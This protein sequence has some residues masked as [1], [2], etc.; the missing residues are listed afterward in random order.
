MSTDLELNKLIAKASAIVKSDYQL[1]KT[2]GI[3][4]QHVS[5]WKTGE[6]VC[7]PEDCARLADIANEDGHLEYIRRTI[8]K[9]HGTTRGIHLQQILFK[10]VDSEQAKATKKPP[11]A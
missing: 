5:N 3:P 10:W 4:Q 2:L 1:A 6:R 11:T 8:K 7:S 9:Y